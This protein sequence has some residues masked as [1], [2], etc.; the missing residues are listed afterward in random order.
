MIAFDPIAR[1]AT[2]ALLALLALMLARSR[3]AGALRW[4][5]PLNA[6][7][8]AAYLLWAWPEARSWPP[9]VRTGLLALSLCQPYLFWLL[10]GALFNDAARFRP[11]HLLGLAATLPPGLAAVGLKGVEP[12]W[13]AAACGAVARLAAVALVLHGLWLILRDWRMDLVE[14]RRRLRWPALAVGLLVA[15]LLAVGVALYAEAPGRPPG[16]RML[17]AVILLGITALLAVQALELDAAALRSLV[18]APDAGPPARRP[19]AEDGEA[20]ALAAL[21]HQMTAL[22]V[23]RE[24]G[25]T[26]GALADRMGLPEYRLRQLINGRLGHRNFSSFLNGHRL[27][28][29]AAALRDPANRRLPVL[30]LALDHGF[31]S[32]GPFNRAFRERYGM[33]PTEWRRGNPAEGAEA[34]RPA[35]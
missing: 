17:E 30:T 34:G 9:P 20:A 29:V 32:I 18:G 1:G 33:T 31:N 16:L 22:A 10:A 27:E 19:P 26:I 7:G 25:L 23:W 13:M 6:L 35:A 28:A 5:A 21:R 15:A 8:L 14:A 2:L 12:A 11:V 4:L 24:A 3:D